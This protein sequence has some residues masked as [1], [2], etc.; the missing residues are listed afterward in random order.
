M[1]AETTHE[2]LP[3]YQ[4]PGAQSSQPISEK[5]PLFP[6]PS[7]PSEQVAA[8]PNEGPQ[9]DPN[10]PRDV[11]TI[12][13]QY[14]DQCRFHYVLCQELFLTFCTTSVRSMCSGKPRGK[15]GLWSI[16]DHHGCREFF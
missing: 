4:A 6:Q 9:V 5:T 14:R 11:S 12:A 13:Q 2:A 15:D 16:W 10:V 7:V 1:A 3:T 8:D